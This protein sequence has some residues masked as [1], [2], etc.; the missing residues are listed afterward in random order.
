MELLNS[1]KD[2]FRKERERIGRI[3]CFLE[4]MEA[5]QDLCAKVDG[6]LGEEDSTWKQDE[7][8]VADIANQLHRALTSMDSARRTST[9]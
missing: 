9:L 3:V 4:R 2:Q 7:Q 1:L 6:Y 8:Q 5:N